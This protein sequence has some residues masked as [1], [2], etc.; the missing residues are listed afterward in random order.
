MFLA[1]AERDF[2]AFPCC[3]IVTVT[4]S[5]YRCG[6]VVIDIAGDIKIRKHLSS[7]QQFQITNA[8]I[9]QRIQGISQAVIE[10]FARRDAAQNDIQNG[11]SVSRSAN[12]AKLR[13]Q[14]GNHN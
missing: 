10:V 11:C 12:F 2:Y 4:V 5:G 3:T 13:L 7:E 14:A 9:K 6:V 8:V 1:V